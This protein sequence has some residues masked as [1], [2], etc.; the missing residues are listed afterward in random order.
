MWV[1][2]Q[3]IFGKKEEGSSLIRVNV[4]ADVK[5]MQQ[6]DGGYFSAM[7]RCWHRYK[8][9]KHYAKDFFV[10]VLH[11]KIRSIRKYSNLFNVLIEDLLVSTDDFLLTETNVSAD[12]WNKVQS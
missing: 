8:V 11:V 1:R 12:W 10:C 3:K 7:Q 6:K 4:V 2:G 9:S 5:K